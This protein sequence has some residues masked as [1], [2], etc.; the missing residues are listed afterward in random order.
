MFLT[1]IKKRKEQAKRGRAV[2]VDFDLSD[3]RAISKFAS[4]N[5]LTRA[6]AVRML[7]LRGIRS[8]SMA[9]AHAAAPV[10]EPAVA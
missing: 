2:L 6:G 1:M 9:P 7:A 4:T 5:G 10:P 8:E 3:D